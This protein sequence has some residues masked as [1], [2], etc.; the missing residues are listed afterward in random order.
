MEDGVLIPGLDH[1]L[2]CQPGG[3]VWVETSAGAESRRLRDIR[4]RSRRRKAT[5]DTP[6]GLLASWEGNGYMG[7]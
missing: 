1:E 7:D 5:K 6:G 4:A 2:V 3:P